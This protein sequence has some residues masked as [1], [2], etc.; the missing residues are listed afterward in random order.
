MVWIMSCDSAGQSE[1]G[2]RP[3]CTVKVAD[4]ASSICS[5]TSMIQF[6][7]TM[8]GQAALMVDGAA[9]GQTSGAEQGIN[10]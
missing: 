7:S 4:E 6:S 8:L 9:S 2:I 5:L 1:C 10:Y 3:I